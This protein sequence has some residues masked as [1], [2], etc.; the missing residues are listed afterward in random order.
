MLARAKRSVYPA[1]PSVHP[2]MVGAPFGR[3][4]RGHAM[5]AAVLA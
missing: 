2:V 1:M 3:V 4:A 5:S